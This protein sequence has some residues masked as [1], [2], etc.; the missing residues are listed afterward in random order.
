MKTALIVLLCTHGAFHLL[1][2]VHAFTPNGLKQFHQPISRNAGLLWL[3]AFLIFIVAALLLLLNNSLWRTSA[4]FA[5]FLSQFLIF[6]SWKDA[7][8]GTVINVL[9]ALALVV[10]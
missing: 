3:F 6:R 2:V 5:I 1:G 8:A 10:G 4:G 9:L 7:R